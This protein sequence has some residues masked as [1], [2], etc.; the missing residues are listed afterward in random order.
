MKDMVFSDAPHQLILLKSNENH[1][2]FQNGIQNKLMIISL[3]ICIYCKVN[4][5]NECLFASR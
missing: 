2:Y 4:V 3:N 1:V 5:Y